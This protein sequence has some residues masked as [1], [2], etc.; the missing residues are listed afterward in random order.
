[1][2]RYHTGSQIDLKPTTLSLKRGIQMIKKTS[3]DHKG[4]PCF[5]CKGLDLVKKK[6]GNSFNV[7]L[8][9]NDFKSNH[10]DVAD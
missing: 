1:M 7:F 10:A 6:T 8:I 5:Y 2:A 4:E 9:R 3:H